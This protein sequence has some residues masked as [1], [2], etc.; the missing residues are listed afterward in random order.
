LNWAPRQLLP[1]CFAFAL[2]AGALPLWLARHLPMVDLPQHLHLISVLHRLNDPGTLYPQLFTARGELTPYLGYYH[3]V[4]GLNWLLPL[5]LANKAFLTTYVVGLPLSLAFLLKSL[6]RSPWPALLALP[7]AYGDSFAWGFVNYCSAL[8]LAFFACGLFVR[9][10]VDVPARRRWAGWLAVCLVAVLLFHVQAY[11][12][13]GLALPFLLFTTRVPSDEKGL[14]GWVKPRLLAV[15]GTLPSIGLFL[16]WVVGRLGQPAAVEAGA[17]WK[18]WGPML[19][20]QNLSFK[21]FEQNLNELIPLLANQLRDGSDRWAVYAALA[22]AALATGAALFRVGGAHQ[23]SGERG[24]ERFRMLGLSVIALALYFALPFD[25][26]GYMYYLSSRFA[27]LAAALA[28]CA[29]PMLSA[30]VERVFYVAAA[31]AALLV[32]VPL[33]RGFRAFSD[34]AA[35]LDELAELTSPK[36]MVMGLIYNSGSRVVT[37]PVFLHA[38]AFLA[39]ERGGAANFSFALT[40]H[41]PLRYRGTPPPTFPSEWRPDQFRYEVQGSA[42][43]HFLVRGPSPE[44][45]F[46]QRLMGELQLAA[47]ARDFWLVRR[48]APGR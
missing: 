36:P 40:P 44:R 3:L 15:L 33:S 10:L 41:S 12:F 30:K 45:I 27:H 37:H 22:L 29:V 21:S 20:P 24:L 46:G 5:P 11:A 32:C 19:S 7:F 48:V 28:V 43:D 39:R 1:A 14:K 47:R 17:P 23:A 6:G 34:E 8:P 42:Y 38:A 18:A 26:R 16:V 31:A 35:A 13:C 9:A 4:S 25:I 2:V